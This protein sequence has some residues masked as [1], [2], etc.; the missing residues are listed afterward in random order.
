MDCHGWHGPA[1]SL[2]FSLVVLAGQT[3]SFIHPGEFLIHMAVMDA[4]IIQI[5]TSIILTFSGA[6]CTK[7]R[8]DS[9]NVPGLLQGNRCVV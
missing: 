6:L 1:A 5:T 3:V 9:L 8:T 7:V 2:W 4:G